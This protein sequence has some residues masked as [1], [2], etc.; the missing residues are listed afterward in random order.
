MAKIKSPFD[1][2]RFHDLRH[3]A[4]T[5]LAESKASD[6]TIMS[7]AGHVSRKMLAHY[8]H[9]RLDA[10][11]NALDALTMGRGKDA[12]SERTSKGYDTNSDTKVRPDLPFMPQIVD[13]LVELSGI[14]PLTSS[15]R[16]RRSPS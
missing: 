14:E 16:T 5:E 7:I 13:S 11:R 6:S 10:K 3:Q 12:D 8:S 4:I 9:V 2:F 15:L 1:G